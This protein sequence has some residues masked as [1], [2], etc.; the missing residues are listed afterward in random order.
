[1]NRIDSLEPP[2]PVR[3]YE[4]AKPGEI[5]QIDIKMLG[6]FNS[7]GHRITGSRTGLS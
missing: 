4:R 6:R 2:V 3:R 7:I 1:L 5:I